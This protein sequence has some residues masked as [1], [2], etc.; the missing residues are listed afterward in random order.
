MSRLDH[1]LRRRLAAINDR[2]TSAVH[3]SALARGWRHTRRSIATAAYHS[4][5]GRG[6]RT[7]V[8]WIHHTYLYRWFT[9]EPEP[10][11]I[12]ID[13]RETYTIGP[14]LRL[15]DCAI[16]GVANRYRGSIVQRGV[17]TLSRP[18]VVG[19]GLIASTRVGRWFRSVLEPPK[20]PDGEADT[21]Q[22]EDS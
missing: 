13:L 11:I 8:R 22:S 10:D 14:I 16:A 5:L 4:A 3:H 7:L 15:I 1:R 17:N 20:A 6:S 19:I 18:I 9:A 12:V 21:N 2:L